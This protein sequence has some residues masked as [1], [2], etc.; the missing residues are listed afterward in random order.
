MKHL[1]KSLVTNIKN[2]YSSIIWAEWN[3]YYLQ[4]IV[5]AIFA[6]KIF[7]KLVQNKI[8]SQLYFLAK[9]H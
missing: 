3:Y 8:V 6:L 2:I 1:N 9:F 5:A 7:T 4:T